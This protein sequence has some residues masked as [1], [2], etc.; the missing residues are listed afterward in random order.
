MR[1][2]FPGNVV[3]D[4]FLKF[5]RNPTLR[6]AK[7]NRPKEMHKKV[8]VQAKLDLHFGSHNTTQQILRKYKKVGINMVPTYKVNTKLRTRLLTKKKLHEKLSCGLKI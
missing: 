3:D 7:A 6:S 5:S 1:A 2:G 8:F 4:T